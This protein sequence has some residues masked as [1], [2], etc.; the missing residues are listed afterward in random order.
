MTGGVPRERP[1]RRMVLLALFLVGSVL[2]AAVAA[3][4]VLAQTEGGVPPDYVP[5]EVV[6]EED[7]TP[8]DFLLDEDAGVVII[9]GDGATDCPSFAAALEEGFL[10]GN[11]GQ[12]RSV[13]EQC[14]RADFLPS[15]GSA[16]VSPTPQP[17]SAP[18]PAQTTGGASAASSAVGA[19]PSQGSEA[20]EVTEDGSVRIGHDVFLDCGNFTSGVPDEAVRDETAARRNALG[21]DAPSEPEVRAELER[22]AAQ[23]AE[24]CSRA[25]FPVATRVGS[26]TPPAQQQHER[27][28]PTRAVL[29]ST[30]GPNLLIPVSVGAMLLMGLGVLWSVAR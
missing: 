8:P 29:P 24:A 18:V 30:G 17:P 12:A 13:L 21:A 3:R 10:G 6:L 27:M 2:A 11:R 20:V 28:Y 7:G 4:P 5:P 15:G 19:N 22:Q 16:P 9:D 14:R 23:Y 1:G 26:A 25:G